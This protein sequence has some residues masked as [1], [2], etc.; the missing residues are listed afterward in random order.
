MDKEKE[1]ELVEKII[2]SIKK[3][4]IN[5]CPNAIQTSEYVSGIGCS[6]KGIECDSRCIEALIITEMIKEGYRKAD[7]VRKETAREVVKKVKEEVYKY[8]PQDDDFEFIINRILQEYGVEVD[9]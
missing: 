5:I 6:D 9:E 1:I 8:L 3:A 2:E 4:I 7:E